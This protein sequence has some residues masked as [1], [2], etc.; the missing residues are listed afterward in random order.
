MARQDVRIW[1]RGPAPT[2]ATTADHGYFGAG[3]QVWRVLL[4]PVVTPFLAPVTALLEPPHMPLQAVLVDHD[5]LAVTGRA[6]RRMSPIMAVRRAQRTV[7]VPVPIILGDTPTADRTAAHLRRYHR[8]MV[9]TIP[10]TGEPY[11]AQGPELV[12]FAHVTIMQAALLVYEHLAYEG[13]HR[14]ARRAP[15][16]RDQFWLEAKQFGIL[17]GADPVEIPTT[18]REVADYYAAIAHRYGVI[19]TFGPDLVVAPT[20]ALLRGFTPG[21]LPELAPLLLSTLITPQLMATLPRP[22]RRNLG[23]PAVLDPFLNL[24]LRLT[25]PAMRAFLIHRF[26]EAIE[27]RISGPDAVALSTHA[28]HLQSAVA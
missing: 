26:A 3:S 1:R 16:E 11:A 17:M 2:P 15:A 18:C 19:D 5:P 28:R 21:Q 24:S 12:L 10:G 20:L 7:G 9:G 6:S 8:P 13:H 14:P 25:R 23:L 27:A 4:H 22:A